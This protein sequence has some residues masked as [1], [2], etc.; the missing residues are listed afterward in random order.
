[1]PETKKQSIFTDLEKATL[2][3]LSNSMNSEI[4]RGKLTEIVEIFEGINAKVSDI[5][6]FGQDARII[7]SVD[8]QE[9]LLR[10]SETIHH[11]TRTILQSFTDA[12]EITSPKSHQVLMVSLTEF[13]HRDPKNNSRRGHLDKDKDKAELFRLLSH[14]HQELQKALRRTEASTQDFYT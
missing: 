9:K 3:S 8:T 12:L 13:V 2:A 7:I 11:R 4:I 1:M 6:E 5:I 14:F 10:L